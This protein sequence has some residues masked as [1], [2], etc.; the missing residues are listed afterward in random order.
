MSGA[1]HLSW[2]KYSWKCCW[3]ALHWDWLFSVDLAKY[4]DPRLESLLRLFWRLPGLWC[5]GCL[6]DV[7]MLGGHGEKVDGFDSACGAFQWELSVLLM[8]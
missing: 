3:A 5:S 6:H 8:L 2:R 1:V 4:A 7:E